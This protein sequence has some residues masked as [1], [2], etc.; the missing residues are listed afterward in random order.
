[1]VEIIK[2]DFIKMGWGVMNRMWSRETAR[3]SLANSRTPMRNIVVYNKQPH[4]VYTRKCVTDSNTWELR[5]FIYLNRIT[6]QWIHLLITI[7]DSILMNTDCYI[8]IYIYMYIYCDVLP[9]KP[10]YSEARC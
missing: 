9:K 8:Y 4:I 10:V 2:M 7:R 3:S 6:F 1:L 5:W